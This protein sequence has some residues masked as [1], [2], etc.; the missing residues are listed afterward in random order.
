MKSKYTSGSAVLIM[1]ILL[2]LAAIGGGV[3]YIVNKENCYDCAEETLVSDED[4]KTYNALVFSFE[5]PESWGEPKV[6]RWSKGTM[7]QFENFNIDTT[8]YVDPEGNGGLI[9]AEKQIKRTIASLSEQKEISKLEQKEIQIS[10]VVGTK[11]SYIATTNGISTDVFSVYAARPNGGILTI[12]Y[13]FLSTED[14]ENHRKI[15]ERIIDSIEFDQNNT[16]KQETSTMEWKTFTNDKYNYSFKYPSDWV[17]KA[18]EQAVSLQTQEHAFSEPS[19][20]GEA[21]D[22]HMRACSLTLASCQ[23]SK[24]MLVANIKDKFEQMDTYDSDAVLDG[25]KGF[26]G[27]IAGAGYYYHIVIEDKGILYEISHN[28][29]EYLNRYPDAFADETVKKIIDSVAIN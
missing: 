25:K 6:D 1:I 16:Q 11:V 20:S 8:A 2:A 10:G 14:K 21:I 15:F 22:F 27:V 29:E 28:T 18:T 4:W 9:P 7:V 26:Q 23:E 3:W 5:Y 19:P 13:E 12:Y 17:I 24:V